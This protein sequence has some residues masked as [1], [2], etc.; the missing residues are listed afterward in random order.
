MDLTLYD[1]PKT[2]AFRVRWLLEELGLDYR[3][4][5][6]DIFSAAAQ[7]PAY[8]AI[9][10]LGQVPA[11][12]ADDTVM[13]ESGA[14]LHW[15]ADIHPAAQ[16]APLP[17]APARAEYEQWMFFAV[18][19]LEFSAWEIALHERIL[20]DDKAV[21]AIVPFARMRYREALGVLEPVINGRDYLVDDRFTA[22]D[23]LTG[24]TLMWFPEL[25][26]DYPALRAYTRR[27]SRRRGFL[28]ARRR[29]KPHT[30][31]RR[32]AETRQAD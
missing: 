12:R 15:L 9:H 30:A 6:V 25:L 31:G 26:D 1:M 4:E 17:D 29:D 18:G 8:R 28:Q 16:L 5:P 23:I 2:R 21:K 3:L 7:S 22:A 27:L 20:P 14:I 24:Q 19:T 10:P 32:H 11:L 13:F